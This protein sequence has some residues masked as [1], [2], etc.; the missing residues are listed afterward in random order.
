MLNNSVIQMQNILALTEKDRDEWVWERGRERQRVRPHWAGWI[1]KLIFFVCVLSI[2]TLKTALF[3][4][5]VLLTV[6][7]LNIIQE[8]QFDYQIRE[9]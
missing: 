9:S 8:G 4:W 2:C 1:W 7:W 6:Q 5:G 3:W